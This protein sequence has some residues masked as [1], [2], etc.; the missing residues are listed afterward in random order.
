VTA[1]T[2]PDRKLVQNSIARYSLQSTNP[3]LVYNAD[4]SLDI[5]MQA[6]APAV[7]K[8]G[9]EGGT[10]GKVSIRCIN[11]FTV[12]PSLPPSLPPSLSRQLAPHPRH[13]SLRLRP[14]HLR[15]GWERQAHQRYV[16][17]SLP[18]SLPPFLPPFSTPSSRQSSTQPP[19]LPPSPPSE[20]KAPLQPDAISPVAIRA[21]A[22]GPS[23]ANAPAAAAV[24]PKTPSKKS[25]RV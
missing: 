23:V 15:P 12:S 25:L 7:G 24:V 6:D 19:S 17:P 9:R 20:L 4:G 22:G 16:P 2:L 10:N 11:M 13:G 8:Q 14:A 1:Y 18:P 3:D 5:L 21:A